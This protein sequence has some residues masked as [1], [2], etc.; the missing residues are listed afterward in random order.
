MNKILWISF[1]EGPGPKILF[2]QSDYC[3]Y[4][5]SWHLYS[6]SIAYT[7]ILTLPSGFT[8]SLYFSSR[9]YTSDY[10]RHLEIHYMPRF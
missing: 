1:D 4:D 6:I 3:P 2:Y 7:Q 8:S 5:T 10:Y 9:S